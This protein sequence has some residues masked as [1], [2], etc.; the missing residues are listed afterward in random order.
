MVALLLV[1][2]AGQRQHKL[3]RVAVLPLF[4]TSYQVRLLG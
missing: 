1:G 3:R 4:L 2:R